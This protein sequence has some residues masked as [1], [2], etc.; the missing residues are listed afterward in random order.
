[1][2]L[3]LLHSAGEP[4]LAS[5]FAAAIMALAPAARGQALRR[6][7]VRV[8]RACAQ[9]MADLERQTRLAGIH[10]ALRPLTQCITLQF[11]DGIAGTS[12]RDTVAGDPCRPGSGPAGSRG[13]HRQRRIRA[14]C[15]AR[16]SRPE[17]LRLIRPH[18][19]G[20]S[21]C[22]QTAS[23]SSGIPEL[24][25]VEELERTLPRRTDE[26]ARAAGTALSPDELVRLLC[27]SGLDVAVRL[28]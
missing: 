17:A 13:P 19:F 11:R 23:T 26:A 14:C 8:S 6:A 9:S 28:A 18:C 24:A 2:L 5:T 20:W 15:L 22:V 25:Y 4:T 10:Y 21:G 7:A 3:D 1:M 12:P 16:Y 27:G